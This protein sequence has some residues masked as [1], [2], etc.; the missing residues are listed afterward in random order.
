L[1]RFLIDTDT[2]SD[3]AVALVMAL[4]DPGVQVEAITVVAG[5]V[6]LDQ[7]VQNALYTVDLCKKQVPVY[8]GASTP[9]LRELE[10]AQYIHGED[11]LGDIGLPLSGRSPAPGNAVDVIVDT[12]NR[13]PG[14]ITLV[15][16]A[17]LTN[18]ALALIFDRSL[19]GK[20]K[21]CVV[22]GGN[23]Q[24]VG[25]V[26]PVAEYNV[27]VDPEAAKV[28]FESGM[29]IKMVDW[30][31]SARH[32]TLSPD[33]AAV[34]RNFDTPLARYSMDIQ[35]AH[36]ITSVETPHIKGFVLADPL[37][38]A[39]AL[40]AAVATETKQLFVAV[41][42]VSSLCRGQT[43]VD[44]LGVMK[45][46]PNAEVVLHASQERFLHMLYRALK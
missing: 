31:V 9:L 30:S 18:I 36:A 41:E 46:I 24:G 45:K 17:P 23:A 12:I 39:V 6:P 27:W 38:M 7:G 16:L 40:D 22:M 19:G 29:P 34:I 43:V 13:F 42:T 21:E 32:A 28:V 3:D 37:A 4:Q 2:A 15:C 35:A 20:V 5:N 26:T 25:N 14:E 33:D 8:R 11:G 44:H 1:R 10:T